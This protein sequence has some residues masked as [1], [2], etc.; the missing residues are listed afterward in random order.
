MPVGS[1][2]HKIY[3]AFLRKGKSKG[4]AARIAQ[5]IAKQSLKTG[6]RIKK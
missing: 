6:K 1:K 3:K 5:T 4:S 2:V